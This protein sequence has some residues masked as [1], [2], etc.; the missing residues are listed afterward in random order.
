M[1]LTSILFITICSTC[2]FFQTGDAA[3]EGT[4]VGGD[5][6]IKA[7]LDVGSGAGIKAELG[8]GRGAGIQAGIGLGRG[9]G[10]KAEL[11][12]GRGA[13]IK[14]G[15]GLGSGAGIKGGLVIG[16]DGLRN[17]RDI[18]LARRLGR[19]PRGIISSKIGGGKIRGEIDGGSE[20]S[21]TVKRE[22]IID[23][24]QEDV[25]ETTQRKKIV[26]TR[27]I[28]EVPV[29]DESSTETRKRTNTKTTIDDDNDSDS[30]SSSE[31]KKTVKRSVVSSG[32]FG[33][34]SS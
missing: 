2:L 18:L 34:E 31:T 11:G 21:R 19:L 6:G 24:G 22:V 17:V 5:G 3:S 27:E 10:I 26:K 33:D 15:L 9:S 20:S 4:V 29:E 30:A 28:K 14:A 7:G 32:D 1:A 23:P 16:G 12:L 25:K 8:L 13:G